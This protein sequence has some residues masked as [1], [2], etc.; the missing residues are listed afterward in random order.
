MSKHVP[1]M[2]CL[3]LGAGLF[4]KADV[5]R[6]LRRPEV[7]SRVQPKGFASQLI[8]R[9]AHQTHPCSPIFGHG[10]KLLA[11]STIFDSGTRGHIGCSDVQGLEYTYNVDVTLY[12]DGER[13]TFNCNDDGSEKVADPT[14]VWRRFEEEG[15]SV[16]L[17]HPQR[18]H[19]SLWQLLA[20][21]EQFWGCPT[22]CNVYLTPSGSQGFAPHFDDIDAFIL[23]IEGSKR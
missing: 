14:T 17:L 13:S 12:K 22:G 2:A 4:S 18:W 23:Q 21:Y 11:C 20:T 15:C 1:S 19:D 8:S 5:D 16:R 7:T 3:P 9:L 10:I 6:L